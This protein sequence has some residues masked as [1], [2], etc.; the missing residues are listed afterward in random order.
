MGVIVG[1]LIADVVRRIAL[2]EAMPWY[3]Y[4]DSIVYRRKKCGLESTRGGAGS[5][6]A[7]MAITLKPGVISRLL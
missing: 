4:R 1:V 2:K 7:E 3:L 5:T 6:P